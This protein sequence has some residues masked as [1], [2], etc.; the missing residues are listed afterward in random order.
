[1]RLSVIVPTHDRAQS[2]ARTLRSVLEL[3]YPREDLEILVV[4]DSST[5]DTAD[6]V[7]ELDRAA[8]GPAIRYIRGNDLEVT[9]ARHIGARAADGELL[10]FIDDD[11]SLAPQWAKAYASAFATHD[12]MAA[13]GGPIRAVWEAPTPEWLIEFIDRKY[14]YT[15]GEIQFGPL[16]LF[17]RRDGLVVDPRGYF[18]SANMAIRREVLFD[19]GGFNPDALGRVVLGDGEIGLA[20]KLWARGL[21]VGYVPEA[22][23][24]HHITPERMTVRYLRRRM[25]RQGSVDAYTQFHPHVPGRLVLSR[26]AVAGASRVALRGVK[27]AARWNRTDPASLVAQMKFAQ[28]RQRLLFTVRLMFDPTRRALVEREDWL[29]ISPDG[30]G[31]G[32]VGP[33]GAAA[34][35]VRRLAAM[36]PGARRMVRRARQWRRARAEREYRRRFAGDCYGCWWGVF[37]SFEEAIHSAPDTKPA[38]ATTPGFAAKHRAMLEQENW[39]GRGGLLNSYDYPVLFWL[40]KLLK[41]GSNRTVFDF[42][43]SVGL[44]FYTYG[45]RLHFPPGLRWTICELPAIA[46]VGRQIA[47]ERNAS[48]DFTTSFEEADGQDVLLA[49]GVLQ[50]V[51]DLGEMLRGLRR[52]PNHVLINRLPIY[53]GPPFVTLQNAGS[54]FCPM[55]VFSRN[56]FIASLDAAGYELVDTW[57]D[58]VDGCFIPFHDKHVPYRGFYL[59]RSNAR[60]D[61]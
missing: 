23:L 16:S 35:T 31:A 43:G 15:G 52:P 3:D 34:L 41:D 4:D 5:D 61:G 56:D 54:A 24:H 9:E 10:L 30:E 47:A 21:S 12:D 42:G 33:R 26:H 6:M 18:F 29:E 58:L 46:E 39:E 59:K 57:D 13:A 8:G 38:G 1:M 60:A 14:P 36:M 48:I 20:S 25:S 2:F 11:V 27:A 28:E 49:S 7:H 51:G 17:E 53:D 37:G 32:V 44:H 55:Y 50:D 22:E 40:S 19:V 45:A